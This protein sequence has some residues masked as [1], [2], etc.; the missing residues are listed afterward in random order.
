[1]IEIPRCEPPTDRSG[2]LFRLVL[3]RGIDMRWD[4]PIDEHYSSV[5]QSVKIRQLLGHLEHVAMASDA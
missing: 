4:A 5:V 2:R 3:G 1:M